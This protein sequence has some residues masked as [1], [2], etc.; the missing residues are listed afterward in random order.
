MKL[1]EVVDKAVFYLGLSDELILEGSN[2]TPETNKKI[3]TLIRCANVIQ[4][5]IASDYIPLIAKETVTSD[6]YELQY[7]YFSRRL[8][9]IN[10][11]LYKGRKIK[12]KVYPTYLEVSENGEIEVQY[13]YLPEDIGLDDDVP[14]LATLSPSTFAYGIA[15]EYAIVNKMYEEAILFERRFKEGMVSDTSIKNATYVKE[16]RWI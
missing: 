5:E 11:C 10:S 15:G 1:R 9:S 16:R 8:I 4:G 3:A 7:S 12:F 2:A 13:N 14:Y 6:N